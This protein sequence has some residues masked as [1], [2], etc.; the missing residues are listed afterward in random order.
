[1]W[2]AANHGIHDMQ[3]A[4][5]SLR[6]KNVASEKHDFAL[7]VSRETGLGIFI[8]MPK[9][10]TKSHG[11]FY[12][13]DGQSV[14]ESRRIVASK[15]RLC[16]VTTLVQHWRVLLYSTKWTV[17]NDFIAIRIIKLQ[18]INTRI[19]NNIINI[20]ALVFAE[21]TIDCRAPLPAG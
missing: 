3:R 15:L 2:A 5:R 20:V 19:S 10:S 13:E 17:A 14:V 16:H 9:H 1:M 11:K 4:S 8:Y 18:L 21:F 6:E 12:P 7:G